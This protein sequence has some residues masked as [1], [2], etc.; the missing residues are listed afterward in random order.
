MKAVL[1]V[2]AG[3]GMV[4]MMFSSG[5]PIRMAVGVAMLVVVLI[6]AGGALLRAKTGPRKQAEDSRER[7]LEHLEDRKTPSATSPKSSANSRRCVTPRRARC[8]M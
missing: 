4:L 1:P 3:M 5:N 2:V 6:T 7:F 8:R